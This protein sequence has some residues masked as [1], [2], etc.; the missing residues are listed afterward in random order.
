MIRSRKLSE[1][2]VFE[3][4]MLVVAISVPLSAC[5]QTTSYDEDYQRFVESV[6]EN[7]LGFAADHWIEMQNITGEWEKTGLVFGYG[8]DFDECQKAIDGLKAA[9]TAREYRC[10]PA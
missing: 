9:N 1:V 6:G 2:S 8:N 5:E 7:K 3:R 4:L 10:V